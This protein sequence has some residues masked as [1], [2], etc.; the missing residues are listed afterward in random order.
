M[1]S[2]KFFTEWFL[3][4][5]W[6]TVQVT[7]Y[8]AALALAVSFLIGTLRTS[9]L[10]IVRFASGTYFEIFRG[11]SA[12]VMMFW[13]AYAVP[14]LLGIQFVP[15]AAGVLALGLTYGAYGSEIVRGALAAVAPAQRE[16]GIAL[17]FTKAQ[18]L[19]K[20]ELP[21]AWPEM[22]PPFNNLLIELLKGTALVSTIAV[23]DMTF[24]G[25]LLRLAKGDSA[26]IYT[27]LLVIYFVFA[28]LLTRGM[29]LL[30]RQAN[31]R[32]GKTPPEKT[33][34][35]SGLRSKSA[36]DAVTGT[37]GAK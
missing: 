23:A 11:T 34:F 28:F 32:M 3:P 33:G 26:P 31:R 8:S 4:G 13:M 27:L 15:M 7:V 6:I 35:L 5:I 14:S 21:Q 37:G 20:I 16:A 29:R 24:A 17:N 12:L 9:P 10:W 30:E 1:M 18:R 19:R 2:E 36:T 22:I 25:N